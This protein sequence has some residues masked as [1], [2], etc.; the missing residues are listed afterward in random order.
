MNSF[1]SRV[2]V[3]DPF[4]LNLKKISTSAVKNGLSRGDVDTSPLEE[5]HQP[6]RW[7]RG[8]F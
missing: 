2:E 6:R 4:I 7:F 8:R 1:Y 5:N 3:D